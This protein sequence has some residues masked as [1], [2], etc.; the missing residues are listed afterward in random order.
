[1]QESQSEILF[2]SEYPEMKEIENAIKLCECASFGDIKGIEQLVKEGYNINSSD[3]DNRTALHIAAAI[4][5][6]D[7]VKWLI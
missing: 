6:L 1:M 3:Y 2:H 7:L 5:N 4:G